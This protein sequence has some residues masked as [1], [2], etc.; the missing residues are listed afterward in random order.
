MVNYSK[1]DSKRNF[2]LI[3]GNKILYINA[4]YLAT[5]S[6]YFDSLFFSTFKEST[7]RKV[8]LY[9]DDPQELE[10]L[11]NYMCPN[12]DYTYNKKITEDNLPI[13]IY[14]SAK[15]LIPELKKE[16]VKFISTDFDEQL[17][18]ITYERSLQILIECINAQYTQSE[19]WSICRNVGRHG[20]QKIRNTM[21]DMPNE[22]IDLVIKYA[23]AHFYLLT[24]SQLPFITKGRTHQWGVDNLYLFL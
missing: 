9:D 11:F 6:P 18:H 20:E 19:C 23:R 24:E 17:K 21:K 16:I 4:H 12:D 14:Y 2:Q 5:L 13:L 22:I 8:T 15:F 7:D 1:A 10:I 3:I